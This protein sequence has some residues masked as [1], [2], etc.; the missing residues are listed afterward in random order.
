MGDTHM[1]NAD[2][3]D[4]C[5]PDERSEWDQISR[6][7]ALHAF[8]GSQLELDLCSVPAPKRKPRLSALKHL[9]A[10]DHG[11]QSVM[12]SGG[13][14]AYLPQDGDNAKPLMQLHTLVTNEDSGPIPTCAKHFRLYGMKLREMACRDIFHLLW[15]VLVNAPA[16][17]G[18]RGVMLITALNA[19][20]TRGP[21][22]GAAWYQQMQESAQELW[23]KA[24][25]TDPLFRAMVP[26]MMKDLGRDAS[27]EGDVFK[28]L[29]EE[30]KSMPFLQGLGP[31]VH[32]TR[33]ASWHVAQRWLLPQN[34]ARAF[35]MLHL[36]LQLGYVQKTKGG[37]LMEELAKVGAA[38]PSEDAAA[39]AGSGASSASCA[40]TA[41]LDMA[42]EKE[43]VQAVRDRCKNTMHTCT[44]ISLNARYATGARI[45]LYVSQP[46]IDW[47]LELNRSLRSRE[48]GLA[49]SIDMAKGTTACA[50]MSKILGA[51]YDLNELEQIGLTI[52]S[53]CTDRRYSQLP[54]DA[55]QV[56]V[57][58]QLAHKLGT[59]QLF[60]ARSLVFN[61][62]DAC[63]LYPRK[64]ALLASNQED[65]KACLEELKA[66]KAAWDAAKASKLPFWQKACKKSHM[67]LTLTQ[68]IL[69]RLAQDGFNSVPEDVRQF[70]LQI[71]SHF[72]S[73]HATEDSFHYIKAQARKSADGHM[74][75][76][77]IWQVPTDRHVL[78]EKYKF[79]EVHMEDAPMPEP[80][81]SVAA[82]V[83]LPKV[84]SAS[85]PQIANITD[86]AT[87]PSFWPPEENH[88][89]VE[90]S[91][92]MLQL[93]KSNEFCMAAG[94][95]RS[96]FFKLGVVVSHTST[97]GYWC[98]LGSKESA[99][100]L[101]PLETVHHNGV[102]ILRFKVISSFSELWVVGITTFVGWKALPSQWASL[103]HIYV[104]AQHRLPECGELPC[105]SMVKTGEEQDFL[106][107]A[108]DCAFWNTTPTMMRKLLEEELKLAPPAQMSE[109]D[110]LMEAIKTVKKIDDAAAA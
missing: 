64:F 93:H 76:S 35:V 71:N 32:M 107:Y 75:A 94:A 58:N 60:F 77:R 40:N 66:L 104:N 41:R 42:A 99:T 87:W 109:V 69:D 89:V 38:L 34:T 5:S 7:F 15:R 55:F 102:N 25:H 37:L 10:L 96:S 6:S 16:Q 95:W 73:T 67:Q 30:I 101:W 46:M 83:F 106:L 85:T 98:S 57:Q 17:A 43:R 49:L 88:K 21:W 51:S 52:S 108:A 105:M 78:D 14:A 50:V 19:N 20:M 44:L 56:E 59:L 90:E 68:E 4:P 1:R 97:P 81:S 79:T 72:M 28:E 110:L 48:V 2:P 26:M 27:S 22:Q 18:L 92:L 12:P 36:G 84:G 100:T 9:R 11:L 82:H 3:G 62:S 63:A 47:L 33:W 24:S 8:A 74:C 70:C 91:A 53:I 54:P 61:I 31:S 39:R 23:S 13:L 80:K 103:L 29:F 86:R 65:Q 45:I